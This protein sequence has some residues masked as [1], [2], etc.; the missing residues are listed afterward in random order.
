MAPFPL[1]FHLLLITFPGH[2]GV[3]DIKRGSAL[4]ALPYLPRVFLFFS[5]NCLMVSTLKAVR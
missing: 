3:M 1:F 2:E 4:P 5:T